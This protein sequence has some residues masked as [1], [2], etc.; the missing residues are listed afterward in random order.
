MF[1]TFNLFVSNTQALENS[2]EEPVV[3]KWKQSV[4]KEGNIIESLDLSDEE[5]I[6]LQISELKK[7]Y[8]SN[9]SPRMDEIIYSYDFIKEMYD[10]GASVTSY[11]LVGSKYDW[12]QRG[13]ITTSGSVTFGVTSAFKNITGS[14]SISMG[15]SQT[16]TTDS[17]MDSRLGVFARIKTNRYRVTK[18]EKYSGRVISTYYTNKELIFDR[19][20][21]PI[22]TNS[23]NNIIFKYSGNTYSAKIIK[24][25]LTS[26]PT[27]A[28]GYI[29]ATRSNFM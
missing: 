10:T 16:Y 2:N 6:Q 21:R 14:A 26:A 23:S 29:N 3:L 17:S 12:A 1:G 11:A 8:E 20:T 9:P 27:S 22:Y 25:G 7:K 24:P 28:S 4:D 5:I 13:S 18:K 19:T 15:T